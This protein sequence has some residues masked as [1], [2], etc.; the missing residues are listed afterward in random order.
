M[1]RADHHSARRALTV[2]AVV[3][4]GLFTLAPA[5][6]AATAITQ[7]TENPYHVALDA[8][9]KPEPFTVVASGFPLRTAVFVEQCNGRSPSD[10][11][12]SPTVDC[13]IASSQAPVYADSKGIA[14]F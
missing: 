10:P 3:A 6:G 11:N 7:P 5:A 4:V 1:T 12:W 14:R 8:Q 9:G 2:A 13:D